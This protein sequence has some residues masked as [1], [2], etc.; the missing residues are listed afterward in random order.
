MGI[1]FQKHGPAV[2]FF[3]AGVDAAELAI[4]GRDINLAA[5]DEGLIENLGLGGV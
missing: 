2:K 4:G 1:V 5:D 3:V